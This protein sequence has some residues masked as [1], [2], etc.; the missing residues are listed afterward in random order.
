MKI[1]LSGPMSGYA[2][3]NFPEF[4]RVAAI[5]RD[6]G[7]SVIDPSETEQPN[8]SSWSE[9]M[10]NALRDMMLCD[11]I[12]MLDGWKNSKGAVIEMNLAMDLDY[13]ILYQ[14]TFHLQYKDIYL[15]K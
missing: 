3:L 12:L 1:Y 6:A 14:P 13:N 9:C 11:S 10:K 5:L 2:D 15:G 7:F 8:I 4:R